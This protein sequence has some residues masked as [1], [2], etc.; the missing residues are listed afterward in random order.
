M[1]SKIQA[2]L[3]TSLP[4]KFL[5]RVVVVQLLLTIM[6]IVS[7]A[8][9][10][11]YYLKTSILNQAEDQ[12]KSSLQVI[13]NSTE[14]Q[15]QSPLELCTSIRFDPATRYSLL[16]WEGRVLCDTA[17][18]EEKEELQKIIHT[19]D[20]E[21][22]KNHGENFTLVWEKI[23]KTLSGTIAIIDNQKQEHYLLRQ[24]INLQEI[25]RS[26]ASFDKTIITILLPVLTV[27][28]LLSLWIGL[29][30]TFPLRSLI[31]KIQSIHR[32]I[33]KEEGYVLDPRDE[34]VLMERT[35]EKAGKDLERYVDELF[36]ENEK[37]RTLIESIS[38]PI[39]AINKSHQI[40][41]ANRSFN[42]RLLPQN[43]TAAQLATLK[44][45][46]LSK[47]LEIQKLIEKVFE[48][49]QGIHR[50]DISF[51]LPENN[52]Y[53]YCN[54]T[55]TPIR[56]LHKNIFGAVCVFHDISYYRKAQQ[57]RED[58]VANVSHEVRT[59]LTALKGYVQL[60]RS[61]D[62]ANDPK[63]QDC[64][65]RIENNTER[66][67]KLFQ[68]VLNLSMIESKQQIHK[69]MIF[70]QE[71]TESVLDNV[72]QNYPNKCFDVSVEY[73][74]QDVYADPMLFEQV[75]TNLIDNAFKYTPDQGK[76]LIQWYIKDE[77]TIFQIKDSGVG[78]AS[79]HLPRLF[80]RFY[81]VDPSRSEMR[82]TGLGL[83]IVKHIIQKHKGK[84]TVTSRLG[85]GTTFTVY[86]PQIHPKTEV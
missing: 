74:T 5:R 65:K 32:S 57:M 44:I 51:P 40:I 77:Q 36:Q 29:H 83:A 58:F 24:T 85:E 49:G 84:I 3:N 16:D 43:T 62:F 7:T 15:N 64:M 21:A 2:S 9:L 12:L 71:L 17:K 82:G 35:I 48:T 34:W 73:D 28:S 59:P 63:A 22:A 60:L 31:R 37:V 13:K 25:E 42:E 20:L 41:F 56:D 50:P 66:V 80:E 27:L 8:F 76:V 52:D 10:A 69:E 67:M 26:I 4:G 47:N 23:E 39:L 55:I 75:V 79:E 1:I 30:F 19:K 38:D 6:A 45:G 86:I 81:R 78:M 14:S 70:T 61:F 53:L 11:R 46:E 72:R 33:G 54:L 18:E 68:D